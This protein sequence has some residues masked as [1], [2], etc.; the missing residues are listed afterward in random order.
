MMARR[1]RRPSK[2]TEFDK[3][4]NPIEQTGPKL[5]TEQKEALQDEWFKS[6]EPPGGFEEVDVKPPKENPVPIKPLMG[7][8]KGMDD[9]L[10]APWRKSAEDVIRKVSGSSSSSRRRRRRRRRR[11]HI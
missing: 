10:D 6:L 7:E 1:R 4:G 9:P 3:R 11:R 2:K 8:I 5:T